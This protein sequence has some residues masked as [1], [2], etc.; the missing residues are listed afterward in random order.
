M[1]R[2]DD[3]NIFGRH[4]IA[5]T[6]DHQT[7]DFTAPGCFK[8]CGH[9]ATGF[10]RTDHNEA[11]L[12]RAWQMMFYDQS[13]LCRSHRRVKHFAQEFLVF[14][15]LQAKPALALSQFIPRWRRAC[16]TLRPKS[17]VSK[18]TAQRLT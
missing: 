13:G 17:F 4:F 11:A 16:L 18:I 14:H 8:G 2:F 7:L 15:S 10:A 5:V 3:L 9:R 12:G 1:C 6:R